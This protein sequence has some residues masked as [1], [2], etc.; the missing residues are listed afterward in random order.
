MELPSLQKMT[1]QG[2]LLIKIII[3][4]GTSWLGLLQ[5]TYWTWTMWS[6]V[7]KRMKILN[8][9]SLDFRRAS[10]HWV[11]WWI[12][13]KYWYISIKK[14]RLCCLLLFKTLKTWLRTLNLFFFF[15]G[16][17]R[18]WSP[19]ITPQLHTASVVGV[20]PVLRGTFVFLSIGFILKLM[21]SYA[22]TM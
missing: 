19:M 21:V 4:K 5:I 11:L 15:F 12:L 7:L 8:L 14:T 16:I 1:W 3:M 10:T 20:Q 17:P 9:K 2:L 6:L 13:S 18:L 22:H